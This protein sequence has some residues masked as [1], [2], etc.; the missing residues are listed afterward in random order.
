MRRSGPGFLAELPKPRPSARRVQYVVEVT[1]AGRARARGQELS[2]PVVE[3]PAQCGGVPAEM[4]ES[5]AIA[6]SVPH[7]A[8]AVPPVPPGFMPVGAVSVGDPGRHNGKLPVFIAGGFVGALAGVFALSSG[9]DATVNVPSDEVN[10]LDSAPPPESRLSVRAFPTLSVRVRVRSHRP[11]GPGLVR[12]IL[13]RAF[14]FGPE[15]PCAVLSGA[16]GGFP[17]S[18]PAEFTFSGPLQIFRVC[19]PTDHIRLEVEENGQV[20]FRTG[21]PGPP[22]PPARYFIDP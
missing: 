5:A 4:A 11:L 14:A 2:A 15:N 21:V 17:A 20:V 3:E 1:A 16:H 7:G 22:D 13:Y 10:F 18:T 12:V 6:V 8:P 19:Q 9:P